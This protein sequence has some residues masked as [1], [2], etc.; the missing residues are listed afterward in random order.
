M[1]AYAWEADAAVVDTNVGRIL[2][3]VNGRPLRPGEAQ[4]QA[5][6]ALPPGQAWRWNQAFMDLGAT[7][8]TARRSAMRRVSGRA[9]VRVAPCRWSG[10]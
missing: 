5:D 4:R 10:P 1:L 8:C 9:R 7:V 6:A 3:R 2:A